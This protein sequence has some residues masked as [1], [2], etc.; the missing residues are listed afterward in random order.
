MVAVSNSFSLPKVRLGS[1]LVLRELG[2]GPDGPTKN[3]RD[4]VVVLLLCDNSSSSVDSYRSSGQGVANFAA[5]HTHR[6]EIP[7]FVLSM[8][9]GSVLLIEEP[10][11]WS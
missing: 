4:C 1:Q 11:R 5:S 10:S 3:C 6:L 9:S 2:T 8:E 7:G